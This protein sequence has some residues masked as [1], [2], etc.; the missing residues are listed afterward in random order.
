MNFLSK[1]TDF[2]LSKFQKKKKAK[3]RE[4][5]ENGKATTTET[6][7]RTR[8]SEN[9]VAKLKAKLEKAES[10]IIKTLTYRKK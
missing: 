6:F 9:L 10:E 7:A 1:F 4:L 3:A 2:Y 5:E 8:H